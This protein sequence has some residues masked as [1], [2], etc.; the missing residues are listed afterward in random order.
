M[1]KILTMALM[2]LLAGCVTIPV[3]QYETQFQ[4]N[5]QYKSNYLVSVAI[6]NEKGKARG[7]GTIIK[8]NSNDRILVLTAAHVVMGMF[9]IGENMYVE[10]S[11][12]SER[13][14]LRVLD[15]NIATDLAV[16][17]TPKKEK[18]MR[19]S[20]VIAS[21]DPMIGDDIYTIGCP[22]GHKFTLTSGII[23]NY[24]VSKDDTQYYRVTSDI[25]FGSSGGGVFNDKGELIGVAVKILSA[26]PRVFVPGGYMVVSLKHLKKIIN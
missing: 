24:R 2:L 20:A 12:K 19:F 13:R 14:Q 1:K 22:M 25:F 7:S 18:S 6:T 11:Y 4:V 9:G 17:Y 5:S 26:G 23:S 10:F 8:A 21:E 16:L 3:K 15:I